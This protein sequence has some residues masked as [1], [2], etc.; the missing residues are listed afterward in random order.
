M[1]QMK[2]YNEQWDVRMRGANK[3]MRRENERIQRV[4]EKL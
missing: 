4:N 2:Q 1:D 3:K